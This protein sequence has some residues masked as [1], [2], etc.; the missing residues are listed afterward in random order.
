[1]G[2]TQNQLPSHQGLSYNTLGVCHQLSSGFELKH[3]MLNGDDDVKV[4]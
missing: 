4:K 2:R 1:M 3:D